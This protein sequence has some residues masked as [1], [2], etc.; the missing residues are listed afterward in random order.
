MIQYMN[1]WIPRRT[2]LQLGNQF[3]D[4]ENQEFETKIVPFLHHPITSQLHLHL[5]T[6]DVLLT[7][8]CS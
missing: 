5:V 3:M 7:L 1:R 4:R 2:M 8:A 6:F